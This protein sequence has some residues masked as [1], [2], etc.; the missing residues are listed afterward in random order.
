[1]GSRGLG[2]RTR[3]STQRVGLVVISR[4]GWRST[5]R[6]Q[7]GRNL[8]GRWRKGRRVEWFSPWGV[9]VGEFEVCVDE[10]GAPETIWDPTCLQMA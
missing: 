6:Q 1:V 3:A 7:M 10:K 8:Q 2:G 9:L 5:F 4:V